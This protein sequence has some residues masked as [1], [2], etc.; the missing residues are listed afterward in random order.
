VGDNTDVVHKRNNEQKY[1]TKTKQNK[2]ID[3]KCFFS[4]HVTYSD[5]VVH[6]RNGNGNGLK[7]QNWTFACKQPEPLK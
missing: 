3:L 5:V 4:G 2:N 7:R 1:K 6:F